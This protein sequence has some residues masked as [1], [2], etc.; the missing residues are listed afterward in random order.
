[1]KDTQ[2]PLVSVPVIAYNSSKTIVETLDSIFNQTYPN[3]ELIVSD[4]GS[5]DNTVQ[6]CR[7]WIEAHKDRF[8]RTELLTVEKNTGISANL[9]RAERACQG[10]WVKGIAGDDLLLPNCV[11]DY[12]DYV[13]EKPDAIY[14]FGKMQFFGIPSGDYSVY[15]KVFDYSFFSLT[16]KEQ[17]HKL[18]FERNYVPAATAF[19]NIQKLKELNLNGNDERIPMLED[20]PKW[21]RLLKNGVVFNF[22]N[23]D[24]VSYRVGSGISNS[25]KMSVI[26]YKSHLLFDFYYRYPE[27]KEER[28]EAKALD[29]IVGDL[30]EQYRLQLETEQEVE[31][32]L[33]TRAY[34]LGKVMLKPVLWIEQILG[35]NKK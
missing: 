29:I 12:M 9:N 20:W 5:T 14:V 16:P 28:G 19:Y 26:Y 32:L 21:I 30:C 15:E 6:V 24:V 18:V 31:R 13:K 35:L 25:S 34:R 2:L 33:R 23:K 8:V 3:L 17:L 22:I 1:M 4:D 10:E 27:W 11:S 7:E